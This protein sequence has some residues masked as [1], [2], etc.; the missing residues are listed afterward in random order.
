M[1]LFNL[2]IYRFLTLLLVIGLVG[3]KAPDPKTALH[4]AAR[5]ASTLKLEK[6]LKEGANLEVVIDGRT[7][8]LVAAKARSPK[9]M[10]I[11]L[12]HGADVRAKDSEG[13]DAWD[14]V[15]VQPGSKHLSSWQTRCLVLLID[16]GVEPRITLLAAAKVSDSEELMERL[17]KAGQD[18]QEVDVNGWTPLHFAAYEGAANACRGLIK[19]GA[20]PNAESTQDYFELAYS[21]EGQTEARDKFRY[22]AGSRP[23]DV[24]RNG[25]SR[26]SESCTKILQEA[27]AA[28]NPNLENKKNY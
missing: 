5:S 2:S 15:V 11:L 6:L 28:K 12:E 10:A 3:C 18:T 27:G 16:H 23:L 25:V 9:N 19:A 13:K 21:A 20:D 17:A 1:A 22:Q 26:T 8:L 24:A 4:R 14:L 7:P